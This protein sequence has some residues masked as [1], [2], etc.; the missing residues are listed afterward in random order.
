M[1]SKPNLIETDDISDEVTSTHA[2]VMDP[3]D[4]TYQFFAGW[5]LSSPDFTSEDAFRAFL[6]RPLER[7]ES[8]VTYSWKYA[9]L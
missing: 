2:L 7:L 5:E 8:P 3:E 6:M 1:S 9:N 4:A